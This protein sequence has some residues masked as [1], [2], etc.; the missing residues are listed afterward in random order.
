MGRSSYISMNVDVD[1]CKGD[2]LDELDDDD[3]IQE[4][5]KRNRQKEIAFA[6]VERTTKDNVSL[7]IQ[8]L[9]DVK[10]RDLMCDVLGLQHFADKD[11]LV[12]Q[13]K[14]RLL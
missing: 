11:S 4:L 10:F 3:L 14:N 1:I 5:K 12:E 6:N 8:N 2:V 7:Y 9:D 13:F